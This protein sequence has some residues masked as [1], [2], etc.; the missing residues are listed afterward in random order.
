[1]CCLHWKEKS[2]SLAVCTEMSLLTLYQPSCLHWDEFTNTLPPELFARKESTIKAVY[3]LSWDEFTTV[4]LPS[5]L[6]WK[7]KAPAELFPL[8]WV[9]YS[10]P[11]A[12]HSTEPV[13]L[14]T[15]ERDRCS[16]GERRKRSRIWIL[17]FSFPMTSLSFMLSR[18]NNFAHA[19]DD[20]IV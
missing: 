13:T 18:L 9:Y 11:A 15:T 8:R 16:A 1:M 14:T 2:A 5:C 7:D 12:E 10:V 3:A 20:K 19:G 4:C 17:Y 6:H